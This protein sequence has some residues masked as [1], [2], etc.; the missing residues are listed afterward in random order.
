M[1]SRGYRLSC[2]GDLHMAKCVNAHRGRW[3]GVVGVRREVKAR[4]VPSFKREVCQELTRV[5]RELGV[6]VRFFRTT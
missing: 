2:T 6:G 5:F 1:W 3:G 4:G